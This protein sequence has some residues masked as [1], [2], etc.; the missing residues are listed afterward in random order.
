METVGKFEFS[1]KDLIGH[2]AFAVVFKGRHKEVSGPSDDFYRVFFFF[3]RLVRAGLGAA[4]RV[5]AR[6]ALSSPPSQRGSASRR[7]SP[8]GEAARWTAQGKPACCGPAGV[9]SWDKPWF[10]QRLFLVVK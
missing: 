5:A 10:P 9:R 6:P 7:A 2:G 4:L 3:S 8:G 1:R